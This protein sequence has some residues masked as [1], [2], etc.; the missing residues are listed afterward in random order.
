MTDINRKIIITKNKKNDINGNNGIKIISKKLNI[1]KIF[2]FIY[3]T[4]IGKIPIR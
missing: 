4:C 2:L 3:Y 1:F